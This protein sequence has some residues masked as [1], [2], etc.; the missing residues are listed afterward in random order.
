MY[1]NVNG[2]PYKT[3][4]T[5]RTYREATHLSGLCFPLVVTLELLVH[6]HL[7]RLGSLRCGSL[8]GTVQG[9]A[10]SNCSSG[11]AERKDLRRGRHS[12][13][14]WLLGPARVARVAGWFIIPHLKVIALRDL[15]LSYLSYRPL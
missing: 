3:G 15:S 7:V 9:I 2:R 12:A 10:D 6:P 4:H 5:R 11:T 1:G 13:A 14:D 8:M